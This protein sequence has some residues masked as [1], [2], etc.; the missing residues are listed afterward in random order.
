MT[1]KRP[2]DR[3]TLRYI[4]ERL[5]EDREEHLE[6]AQ[7]VKAYDNAAGEA[8]MVRAEEVARVISNIRELLNTTDN[9]PP[10]G[11]NVSQELPA[12]PKKSPKSSW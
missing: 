11:S 5:S 12:A 3:F 2:L 6:N 7:Q 10:P 1:W 8:Y 9:A 4:L